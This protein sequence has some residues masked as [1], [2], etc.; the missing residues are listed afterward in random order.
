MWSSLHTTILLPSVGVYYSLATGAQY[1]LLFLS[2]IKEIYENLAAHNFH[3][4]GMKGEK[5][6]KKG[7]NMC[8]GPE[9]FMQH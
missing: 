9:F 4:R 1:V 3:V 8:S 7:R 2:R 5:E 6:F